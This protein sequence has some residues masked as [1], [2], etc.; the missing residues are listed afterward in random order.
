M[1]NNLIILAGGASSRMKK[2]NAANNLSQT[3][4]KQAN[5]RSKGLIGVGEQGLPFLH[6]LLYNAKMAG[7]RNIYI[8]IGE[9]DTHFQEIYGKKVKNNIFNGLSISFARQYVPEGRTKPFG[10]ADAVYQTLE[11]FPELQTKAFTVCNSDNLYSVEAL[12]KLNE[13]SA[14]HA[15]MAYDCESLLYN[16]E[17]ISRFALMIIDENQF[18]VD[19]VEKPPVD[20]VHKYEDF[21]GKLRVSMNI[22]KFD[23]KTFFT[24]LRDCPVHPDRNEKELPTALMNMLNDEPKSIKAIPIAEHVPDLTSKLD[25][26]RVRNFLEKEYPTALNW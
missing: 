3:D 4:I 6:Y 14:K 2:D 18:L 24:Y 5:S 25:I 23:G 26:G 16:P 10:T 19:I 1:H 15:L 7:Y 22:F 11:Q 20:E 13:T 9:K 8:L 17:R 12:R 21:D